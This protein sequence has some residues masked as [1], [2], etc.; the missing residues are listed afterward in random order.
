VDYRTEF[1]EDDG[2]CIVRV[3]GEHIRPD[4]SQVL[5]SIAAD[6]VIEKGVNLFLFDLREATIVESTVGAYQ[7]GVDSLPRGVRESDLRA[8]LVYREIRPVEGFLEDVMVNRGY[9]LKV[10]DD[11]DDALKWLR[12]VR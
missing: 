10:F 6:W 8:A 12:V 5:R 2:I 3:S 7:A 11:A 4:D 9:V 1:L